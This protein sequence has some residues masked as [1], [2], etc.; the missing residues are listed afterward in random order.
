M[1]WT[2]F[3]DMHSGGGQ[4]LEWGRIYIEGPE[5]EACRVFY[6]RFDSS[7]H[8]VSC[9]CCGADYSV[10][11]YPTLE[12]ATLF[13]RQEATRWRPEYREQKE[14]PELP[15]DEYLKECCVIRAAEIK[16]EERVIDPPDQGYVWVD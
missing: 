11:E 13:D 14:I 15:L 10:M 6:A 1:P 12:E 5:E 4:K 2:E 7:P 3:H 8:R 9:T 16:S